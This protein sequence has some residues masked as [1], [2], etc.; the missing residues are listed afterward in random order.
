MPSF[1]FAFAGLLLTSLG[2]RDQL[3]IG[4]LTERLG[5]NSM[6]LFT[7]WS[8]SIF[9]A[10]LMAWAGASIAILLPVAAKNMLI[11]F[12]LAIAAFELFWPVRFTP[13]SE[14]TR[15]LGAAFLVLLSRQI[16]DAPRFLVFA[17]AAGTGVPWL[18]GLGGAT[19]GCGALTLAWVLGDELATHW[20]LR[21]I[22]LIMGAIIAIAA[23]TIGLS[24][25]GLIA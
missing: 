16:G 3:L 9:S 22:R 15:S 17:F 19:G 12:A 25:R 2:N 21:I 18:A 13:P 24:A 20:P 4:S 10:A 8:A 7:A 5:R 11:A 6:L 14:P 23:I 1:L